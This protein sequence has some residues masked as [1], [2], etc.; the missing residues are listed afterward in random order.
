M[1]DPLESLLAHHDLQSAQKLSHT[2]KDVLVQEDVTLRKSYETFYTNLSL[3]SGGTIAL[4]VTYLGYL[5]SRGTPVRLLAVLIASWACLLATVAL[6]LFYSFLH[7][8]YR[9][10]ARMR[11]YQ[12]ALSTQ[13]TAESDAVGKVPIVGLP[14]GEYEQER[15]RL[16]KKADAYSSFARD[17]KK[18]EDRYYWMWRW[19]GFAARLLFV[20]GLVCLFI[21]AT[22]NALH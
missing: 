1:D 8:H 11:E 19:G 14:P 9:Y 18:K 21:F 7:S 20:V 2:V 10:H 12:E 16:S 17:L 4:S 15:A 22:F 3:F 13:K 6:G 5:R